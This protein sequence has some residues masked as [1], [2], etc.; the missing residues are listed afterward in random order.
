[1]QTSRLYNSGWMIFI[2]VGLMSQMIIS[3]LFFYPLYTNFVT[4][5]PVQILFL[6]FNEPLELVLLGEMGLC[7]FSFITAAVVMFLYAR[8]L[9][10]PRF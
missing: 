7:V 10:R 4:R 3:I 2:F 1:M 9:K 6:Q 5:E 8:K